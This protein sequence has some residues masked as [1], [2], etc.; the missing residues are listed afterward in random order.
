MKT[1]AISKECAEKQALEI[2]S[3][4]YSTG[5]G[6]KMYVKHIS[7]DNDG[8]LQMRFTNKKGINHVSIKLNGL[9]Y[10]DMQFHECRV[11]KKDPYVI[12]E[13]GE[14]IKN[15]SWDNLADAIKRQIPEVDLRGIK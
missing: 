13:E 9:D 15:I 7:F 3:Q 14:S 12:N 10:Y 4:I 1:E 5:P 11:L 2:L 8:T 6:L